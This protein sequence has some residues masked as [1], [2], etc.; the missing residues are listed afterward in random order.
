MFVIT[1]LS[2]KLLFAGSVFFILGLLNQS[3][4]ITALCRIS[5]G[6]GSLLYS[7]LKGLRIIRIRQVRR[8][9]NQ[10]RFILRQIIQDLVG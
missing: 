5:S 4:V 6:P 1:N 3:L 7:G 8:P 10:I 2:S 9:T